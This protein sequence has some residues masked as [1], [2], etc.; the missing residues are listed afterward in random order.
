MVNRDIN[1]DLMVINPLVMVYTYN[2]TGAF[3]VG[4]LDGLLGVDGMIT[5]Y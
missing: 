1:G 3:Y 4:C 5:D 2:L